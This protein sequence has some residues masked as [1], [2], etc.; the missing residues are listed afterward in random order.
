MDKIP[1]GLRNFQRV[2]GCKPCGIIHQAVQPADPV[3]D[4]IEHST[5]L[6]HAFQICLDHAGLE[7]ARRCAVRGCALGLLA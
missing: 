2:F 6:L 4:L 5:D 3:A 7:N 1:I